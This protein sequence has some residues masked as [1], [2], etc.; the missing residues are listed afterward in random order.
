MAAAYYGFTAREISEAWDVPLGTVKT[1]LRLAM[2]RLR[3]VLA[4]VTPLRS[5][6]T[7]AGAGRSLAGALSLASSRG[8]TSD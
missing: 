8:R 6:A 7:Q 1:R 4:E 2:R 3:S 5:P